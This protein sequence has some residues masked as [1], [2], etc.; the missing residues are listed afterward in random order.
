MAINRN[1]PSADDYSADDENYDD[2][3]NGH[4]EDEDEAEVPTRSSMIQRGWGAAKQAIAESSNFINELKLN[5][6]RLIKFQCEEPLAV[7]TQHFVNDLK[8][9]KSHLCLRDL[10]ESCPFCEA[11]L[12]ADRKFLFAVVEVSNNPVLS[13]LTA[14]PRMLATLEACHTGRSG[15][16]KRGY[17]EL[18]RVGTGP[19]TNYTMV[20]VHELSKQDIDDEDAFIKKFNAI[21]E[22]DVEKIV[23]YSDA[24]TLK[25]LVRTLP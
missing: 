1:A 10:G 21:P 15:P 3:P 20:P 5:E 24:Q 2:A 6:P 22:L 14:G 18:A 7:F 9:K 17:W 16:L 11:G 8:G 4:F 13:T 19:S 23:R 25:E 12:R